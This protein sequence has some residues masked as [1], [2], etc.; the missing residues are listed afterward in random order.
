MI[1]LKKFVIDDDTNIV[2]KRN[3]NDKKIEGC[4]EKNLEHNQ[5]LILMCQ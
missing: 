5:H 4:N 3:K 1:W 2:W